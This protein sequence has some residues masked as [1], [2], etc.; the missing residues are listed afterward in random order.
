MLLTWVI[1]LALTLIIL[2]YKNASLCVFTLGLAAFCLLAS[3]FA[4][5]SKLTI[6]VMWLCLGAI[7]IFNIPMLR[8]QLISH[9]LFVIYKKIAPHITQTEKDA[10]Q[11]GDPWWEA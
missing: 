2:I 6:T 10:L 7:A 3:E 9:K 5:I 4:P 8:R 1:L 11:A